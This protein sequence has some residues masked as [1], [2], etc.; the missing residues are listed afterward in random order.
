MNLQ[1]SILSN[2]IISCKLA[3]KIS[4]LELQN[5][6][7][8]HLSQKT[9]KKGKEK[10]SFQDQTDFGSWDS[11]ILKFFT[12]FGEKISKIEKSRFSGI[13]TL[14]ALGGGAQCALRNFNFK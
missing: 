10:H 14:F 12:V 11:I 2:S 5:R 1:T 7:V 9:F 3:P 8:L 6:N 13:L 4:Y